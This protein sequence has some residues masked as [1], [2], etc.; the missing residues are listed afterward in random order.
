VGKRGKEEGQERFQ[1]AE[2]ELWV[3][4]DKGASVFP[5][6]MANIERRGKKIPAQGKRGNARLKGIRKGE[7]KGSKAEG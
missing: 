3:L 1:K 6:T 7:K 4:S 2:A 5:R